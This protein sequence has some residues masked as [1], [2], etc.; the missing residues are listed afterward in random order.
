MSAENPRRKQNTKHPT[1]WVYGITTVPC[2][3]DDLLRKTIA[4]LRQ[5]GFDSPRLFIDGLKNPKDYEEYNLPITIREPP[6]LKIVGN[7]VLGMW[8]LFVREPRAD[9]YCLF[10]DDIEVVKNLRQYLEKCEY[11]KKGYLN[12]Y[13]FDENFQHTKGN[14]G[15]NLSNQRGLGALGLVFTREALMLLLAS[16]V[17]VNKPA[18]LGTK[19]SWKSVDGGIFEAMKN[20]GWREW[21]HNPS[22]IQHKGKTST[23]GNSHYPPIKSFPGQE[24]DA[25]SLLGEK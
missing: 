20:E 18:T 22:L 16:K 17:M 15:W 25:L 23:L 1:Q 8:E 6:P 13:T 5:G 2:R 21:I 4:S 7:W 24:F 19:R 11:P 12:L 9:R 10:Q 3:K 14:P